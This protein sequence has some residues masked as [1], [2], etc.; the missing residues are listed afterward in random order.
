M[1]VARAGMPRR[2]IGLP[3]APL[4]RPVFMQ[5]NTIPAMIKPI[6][7]RAMAICAPAGRLDPDG[8][9]WGDGDAVGDA[10]CADPGVNV[11]NRTKVAGNPSLNVKHCVEVRK[12]GGFRV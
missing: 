1:A 8:E 7:T 6:T 12:V 9:G 2:A 11:V 5:K 3:C 10:G 4:Q